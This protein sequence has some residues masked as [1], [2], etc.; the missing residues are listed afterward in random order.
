MDATVVGALVAL[1][2]VV[3]GALITTTLY[4]PSTRK[5]IALVTL[6]GVAIALVVALSMHLTSR[7]K[8]DNSAPHSPS[9]AHPH[10]VGPTR[11]E[12][13]GSHRGTPVYADPAGTAPPASVPGRIPFGT[14]VQVACSA[15]NVSG[16]TS[17]TAFYL[18]VGGRWDG[19]FAVS[20][21]F[22]NGDRLG[23]P[24]GATAVDPAVPRCK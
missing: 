13:A 5:V 7:S 15:P 12:T 2:A 20:D 17:V 11:V 18:I 14:K 3:L 10:W 21:T 22:A 23:D 6:G 4:P 8:S 1:A 16:M 9:G 24:N 19:L